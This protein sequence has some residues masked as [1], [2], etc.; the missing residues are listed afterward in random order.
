VDKR[1]VKLFELA[2][3]LYGLV[4]FPITQSASPEAEMIGA[5]DPHRHDYY[6]I[7][8][9]DGGYMEVRVDAQRIKMSKHSIILIHPG[10]VHQVLATDNISGWVLSFDTKSI[11]QNARSAGDQSLRKILYAD[12]NERDF[13]FFNDLLGTIF[14]ETGEKSPGLF[15]LQL[16]HSLV[17]VCFYKM[18]GLGQVPDQKEDPKYASRPL[19]LTQG[20]KDLVARKFTFMKKPA[21][22]ASELNVSVSHLNDTI[23]ALSGFTSTYFIHQEVAGEAQ[24]Q[25]LY[26][27]KSIKEVAGMLGYEDHK[28]F[29]RL[30]TR[31][32]GISPLQYRKS[33]NNNHPK[34][35]GAI[36]VFKT[37]LSG[38]QQAELVIG[39]LKK[40]FP[41]HTITLGADH[42]GSLVSIEGTPIKSQKIIRIFQAHQH[43][44]EELPC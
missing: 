35:G 41:Y 26:S 21:G 6:S 10:Q 38:G 39:E 25:L 28:Y 18:A 12:L 8:L 33:G 40:T 31:I 34:S 16:L 2:Q 14:L 22:Y 13:H 7:F 9:L 3:S 15:H 4:I 17:N 11:D 42:S 43:T 29:T 1:E 20:F 36:L 23:K 32:V 27:T 19:E 5:F 24:R 44:C 37:N 30:F